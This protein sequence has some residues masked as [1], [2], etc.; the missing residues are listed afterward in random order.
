MVNSMSEK[1]T[2]VIIK[3]PSHRD[4]RI[5]GCWKWMQGRR[6]D[7]NAEGLWRVHDKLYDLTKFVDNHPGGRQWLILTRVRFLLRN[8]NLTL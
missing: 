6:K 3:Y 1:P 2:S 7:D 8:I 4:D 5:N